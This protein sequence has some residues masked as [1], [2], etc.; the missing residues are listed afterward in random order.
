MDRITEK[1]GGWLQRPGNTKK[2]MA[3]ELGITPDSLTN[4]LTGETPWLWGEV[5]TA[6]SIIGCKVSDFC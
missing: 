3:A 2:K 1:V 5:K 6:A 4:K